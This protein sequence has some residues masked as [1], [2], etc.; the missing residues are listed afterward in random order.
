[1]EQELIM[2]K[3]QSIFS[4]AKYPM[5]KMKSQTIDWRKAPKGH[6]LERMAVYNIHDF[7][8]STTTQTSG[9]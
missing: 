4:S 3:T 5:K 6:I 2:L 9:T 7:K 8:D 1:M